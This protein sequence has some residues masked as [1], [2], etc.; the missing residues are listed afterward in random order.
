MPV[1]QLN[2]AGTQDNYVDALSVIF[3]RARPS[4]QL[5][6]SNNI[7][8]YQLAIPGPTGRAD[9][10]YWEGQEHQILPSLTNFDEADA[11]QYGVRWLSG[12]RVRSR[13]PTASA[14]VSVI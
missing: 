3:P 6:V 2:G 13:T 1:T 14:I 7:I 4:F 11:A 5:Q 12:I 10:W 8:F 9:D